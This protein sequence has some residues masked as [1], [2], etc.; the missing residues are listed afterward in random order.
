SVRVQILDV[1]T[2]RALAAWDAEIDA[3]VLA[4]SEDGRWLAVGA[5]DGRVY[6]RDVPRDRPAAGLRGHTNSVV[7]R[8]YAH[9][10]PLLA[11]HRWDGTTRLWDADSGEGL[12]RVPG[13]FVQFSADD[14]RLACVDHTRVG[15]WNVANGRE[16][17]TL[18]QG[19]AATNAPRP[20]ERD[21]INSAG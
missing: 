1:A 11:T 14:R 6:V 16:C 10:G 17:R 5:H 4:W 20:N 15:A 3:S 8:T 13:A 7:A 21:V 18:R 2:G 19:G 9:A 12:A